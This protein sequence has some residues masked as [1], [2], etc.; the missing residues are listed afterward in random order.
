MM[1]KALLYATKEKPYLLHMPKDNEEFKKGIEF[2]LASGKEF[3]EAGLDINNYK[4]NGK[5]VAEC[6]YEVEEI[7]EDNFEDTRDGYV[8]HFYT[9]KSYDNFDEGQ[10]VLLKESCLQKHELSNYLGFENGYAIHIKSLHIF[11]EP[12]ELSEFYS[13]EEVGGMLFTKPLTKAPQNMQRVSINNW[14]YASYNPDDI[15]VLISIRSPW[16]CLI[17][18]RIKDIEVRKSVLNI[19]KGNL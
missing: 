7:F 18:N 13:I 14:G 16:M 19:M 6:D 9:L 10:K 5:V 11:D 12:K 17:L 3:K 8:E 1:Q 2:S 15:R 4:L